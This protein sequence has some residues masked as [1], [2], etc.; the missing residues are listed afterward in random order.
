MRTTIESSSGIALDL[1]QPDQAHVSLPDIVHS[2]A[3]QPRL[4]GATSQRYSI[5]Q[6]LLT[7]HELLHALQYDGRHRAFVLYFISRSHAAFIGDVPASLYNQLALQ[8]YF[9]KLLHKLHACVAKHMQAV[10]QID[11]D[12]TSALRAPNPALTDPSWWARPA[13]TDVLDVISAYE[14]FHLLQGGGW[15]LQRN[16]MPRK[17]E[18]VAKDAWA[19]TKYRFA[20]D[21]PPRVQQESAVQAELLKKIAETC[22]NL[23]QGVAA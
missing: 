1:V 8:A 3:M 17:L 22:S 23:R 13:L 15:S 7:V 11:G 6:H 10:Y 21:T 18:K 12:L 16:D 9:T 2:L 5:A 19:A 20:F 4:L 14:T